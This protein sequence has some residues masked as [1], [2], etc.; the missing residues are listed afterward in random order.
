MRILALITLLFLSAGYGMSAPMKTA[1]MSSV[2]AGDALRDA[3]SFVSKGYEVCR[4]EGV[5]MLPFY[6]EHAILLIKKMEFK[7]LKPGMLVVYWDGEDY[8]A[9]RLVR[10]GTTNWTAK[11]YN[12]KVEDPNPV[13][14]AN[15]N[16]VI[17]VT[18]YTGS[19][20]TD[21]EVNKAGLS[22][23]KTVKAKTY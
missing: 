9:H 2:S 16:G 15:Y 13:T 20:V 18:F 1:P 4:V 6:N 19:A 22:N 3:S 14:E 17:A 5:S 23:V 12:N 7:A 8:V 11:G 21:L 10:Q